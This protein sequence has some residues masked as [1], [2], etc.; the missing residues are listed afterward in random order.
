MTLTIKKTIVVEEEVDVQLPLYW[1]LDNWFSKLEHNTYIDDNED[2]IEAFQLTSVSSNCMSYT[3]MTLDQ[4]KAY[5]GHY[6]GLYDEISEKEYQDQF[7][8]LN[9]YLK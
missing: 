4:F 9:N 8:K 7:D 1:Q 2:K 3:L 6:R 5:Y